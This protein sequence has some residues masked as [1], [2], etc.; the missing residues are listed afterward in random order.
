MRDGVALGDT[1]F[2][3]A[4][5]AHAALPEDTRAR[6][7]PLRVRHNVLGRRAGTGRS[8]AHDAERQALADVVHP[9]ARVNPYSGARALFVNTGECIAIDGLERAEA[10][11]LIEELAAFIQQGAFRYRHSWRVG[12]VVVWDNGA[13]QHLASFDYH[14][15][16]ERRLLWRLTVG[17]G[18]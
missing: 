12:D 8:A 1:H 3:S 15:P 7:E 2:A 5:A 14:W 18:A 9:L 4:V 13:V 17:G 6:I 11:A 16:A 10:L